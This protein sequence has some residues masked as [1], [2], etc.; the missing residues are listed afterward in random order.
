MVQALVA[1]PRRLLLGIGGEPG[2]IVDHLHGQQA[3]PADLPGDQQRLG[4]GV[5][6]HVGEGFLHR[7]GTRSPPASRPG[8]RVRASESRSARRSSTVTLLEL[9]VD[10]GDQALRVCS[11]GGRSPKI[12]PPGGL[13]AL[14][15][16]LAG[17][18]ERP[19]VAVVGV[20]QVVPDVVQARQGRGQP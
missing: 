14:V 4:V 2:P 18:A 5:L 8:A 16:R 17:A 13:Q 12:S 1:L 11:R 15:E 7:T 6:D 10:R 9:L 20:G 3:R 19:A